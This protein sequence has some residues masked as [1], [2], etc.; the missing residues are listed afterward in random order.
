MVI[1]CRQWLT[2]YGE[3]RKYNLRNF[4]SDDKFFWIAEKETYIDL[5]DELTLLLTV[6]V[7]Y[8]ILPFKYINLVFSIKVSIFDEHNYYIRELF[9]RVLKNK[10]GLISALMYIN[11]VRSTLKVSYNGKISATMV[12]L[13]AY[14]KTPSDMLLFR[15]FTNLLYGNCNLCKSRK[16]QSRDDK[17]YVFYHKFEKLEKYLEFLVKKISLQRK[18]NEQRKVTHQKSK[19]KMKVQRFFYF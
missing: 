5:L 7:G 15:K 14:Y 17:E 9:R 16:V 8:T 13:I 2:F 3:K 1:K 11:T 18:V 19:L 10:K 6:T 12:I 4:N